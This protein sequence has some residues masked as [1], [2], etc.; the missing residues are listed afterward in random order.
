MRLIV[1]WDGLSGDGPGGT[2]HMV[3]SANAA[4]A[5]VIN[6]DTRTLFAVALGP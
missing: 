2:Q 6:L 5:E 4:G 1:L 3:H